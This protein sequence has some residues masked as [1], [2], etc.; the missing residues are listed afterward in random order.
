MDTGGREILSLEHTS[1]EALSASLNFFGE[2][3]TEYMLSLFP[4]KSAEEMIEELHGYIYYNP[5]AG[6]YETS[7]R[8]IAGNVIEKVLASYYDSQETVLMI[9]RRFGVNRDTVV[10]WVRRHDQ[11]KEQ[12]KKATFA[13][14]KSKQMN[15][16]II[17]SIKAWRKMKF[18][19]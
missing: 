16:V 10:S 5:L 7:D 9:A 15:E 13:L 11:A 19:V 14:S 17:A 4:E 3:N 1:I 18:C 8:F 6:G 12:S 2:V